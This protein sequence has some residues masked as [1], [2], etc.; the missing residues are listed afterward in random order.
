MGKLKFLVDIGVGKKAERW[1]IE[2]GNPL[3]DVD[4]LVDLL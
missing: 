2:K 1:L 3:G 4:E